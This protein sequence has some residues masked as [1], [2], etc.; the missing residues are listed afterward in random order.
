MTVNDEIRCASVQD[1]TKLAVS[2]HPVLAQRLA[3]EGGG[4][5]SEVEHGDTHVRVQR[6]KGSFQRLA[7]PTSPNGKPLQCARV[8]RIR[9]FV[10]PEPATATDRSGDAD[11]RS[12]RQ[13]NHRGATV[14]HLDSKTFEHPPE[15]YPAQRAEVVVAE[16]RD[17][18][19]SSGRQE[20]AGDLGFE[21]A[22]V[23]SQVTGDKQEVGIVGEGGEAGDGT[24]VFSTADVEVSNRRYA[25]SDE[26]SGVD[27]ANRRRQ[28]AFHGS[29]AYLITREPRETHRILRAGNH[30]GELFGGSL[31]GKLKMAVGEW[32]R[33]HGV[34]S[35]GAARSRCS[36]RSLPHPF[37]LGRWARRRRQKLPDTSQYRHLRSRPR[38]SSSPTSRPGPSSSR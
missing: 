6:E 22:T 18:R 19:Q 21:Q 29:E 27:L 12:V 36:L 38:P 5:R 35:P 1:D 28:M 8:N 15:R 23:L 34:S 4:G 3:A 16:H 24:Q 32:S 2:E 9:A 7:L 13:A 37:A 20:L 33:L 30:G 10:W 25:N 31:S 26:V 17:H 11:T 14:E